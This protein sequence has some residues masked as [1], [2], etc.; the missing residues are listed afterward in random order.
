MVDGLPHIVDD[1]VGDDQQDLELLVLIAAWVSLHVVVHL[2]E[3]RAEVGGAV[4]VYVLEAVSV[5]SDHFVK[6]VDA[7]VENVSIHCEA[8]ARALTV[9]GYRT[10]EAV[11]ID[12]LIGVVELQN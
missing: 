1:T 9:R 11:K 8:V 6:S 7:G 2:I 12:V 4:Q 5:V 10:T 3:N